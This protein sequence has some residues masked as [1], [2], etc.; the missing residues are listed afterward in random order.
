MI[1]DST[2]YIARISYGKDSLK[3]LDVIKGRGLPL[4][5]ITTTEVWATDT[6]S[7]NLPPMQKFKERMDQWIWDKYRIEV[8]HLC[9]VNPDGTKRTYEQM[10]YHVPKRKSKE[11]FAGRPLGFPIVGGPWCQAALKKGRQEAVG[12]R[13]NWV[14]SDAVEYIGIAADEPKRFG[15]LNERKRAPLVE[16]GIDEE[17]CGLYCR[18]NGIL[19][20]SYET[21]FRDGCWFCHNQGV[22]QLRLLRRSYPD[23]WA[24]LMRWD[25]DSPTTFK[26]DCRTVHDYDLWF[27]LE[28]ERKIPTGRGFRW[29]MLE[30]P[31]KFIAWE[32]E[33]GPS[34]FMMGGKNEG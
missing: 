8:E 11:D 5:R 33:E 12:I 27:Q 30:R 7:A 10:F 34:L 29:E 25:L 22:G 9:A 2:Q 6:I 17:L 13:A 23:L 20:P 14:S 18:Y 31:P 21:S 1:D 3:M 15:Q 32:A 24:I 4:D 19:S 26:A 16:F 28:D